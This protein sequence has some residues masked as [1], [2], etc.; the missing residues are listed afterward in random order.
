MSVAPLF[1]AW[2]RGR[3][4]LVAALVAIVL[5]R[6]GVIGDE[7]QAAL[8]AAVGQLTLYPGV[9]ATL[10]AGE[11]MIS[12]PTNIDV[13]ELGRVWVCDVENYR[14]HGRRD[15]RPEGD[16]ILILEDIDGDGVADGKKVFYQGRDVDAA[17]GIC[18]FDGHV[19]VTCAPNVILFR[20]EDGD[21]VPDSKTYLFSETGRPQDDHSTH[22]FVFGPDGRLYWNM[23][24]GGLYVHD[25]EGRQVFD[26]FGSPVFDRRVSRSFPEYQGQ[27]SPFLGGMVFRCALD[28]TDFEV[29]GHNFRNNYEVTVDSF[30]NPWQSDNDDDGNAGV[31]LNYIMEYGNY[32]YLDEMTA[33]SW[34]VPRIGEHPD[35]RRRHWHQNDPGVV[36][37][38]VQTGAGSPTG[39]TVYE[40][41]LLPGAFHNKVLH[42]DAGPG[43]LWAADAVSQESGVAGTMLN[44]V[45]NKT[46]RSFRPVDVAVAPDGSLFLSD[47]YDPVIGW[48]R[49]ADLNHGRIFRIAP[50][51]HPYR[52]RAHDFRSIDGAIEALKNP[53]YSVRAR[54]WRVLHARGAEAIAALETMAESANPVHRARAYWL[55][56]AWQ[57]R[58]PEFVRRAIQDSNPEIRLVGL[59]AAARFGYPLTPLLIDLT[60]DPSPVVRRECAVTLRRLPNGRVGS[61]WARLAGG[62]DG[63]DRWY[64]EALGIGAEGRWDE[65]LGALPPITRKAYRQPALRKLLWRSRA[66][67]TPFHL[68]EILRTTSLPEEEIAA[69]LRAFDFQPDTE[70]RTQ[71]LESLLRGQALAGRATFRD[72]IRYE[73]LLRIA[74]SSHLHKM[75]IQ[76]E[77]ISLIR[78][79]SDRTLK[80]ELIRRFE[81]R[82][83]RE[84]LTDVMG[85]E[86]EDTLRRQA[87]QALCDLGESE[88]LAAALRAP[89]PAADRMMEIISGARRPELVPALKRVIVNQGHSF[90]S[91][92]TA[93]R[94]LIE[95]GHGT[96]E[97]LALAREGGFPEDLEEVAGHS[98]SKTLHVVN[99]N[100]A[101]AFFPVPAMKGNE[102]LPG[103]TEL[104]VFAGDKTRG[105]EIF[106]EAS[107]AQC[108]RVG[109][110]GM[111]YGPDLS[112]I[113]S[114]L[115]KRGL[116]ESILDPDASISPSYQGI[117]V[118]LTSGDTLTGLLVSD[119]DSELVLNQPGSG[120]RVLAKGKISEVR[121]SQISAMP[122][123]LHQL[124]TVNELVDLVEFLANLTD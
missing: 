64:L 82:E 12:N 32:G 21:D 49:Q 44:L 16:Q 109:S 100:A 107:C 54:A 93:L 94:E 120:L 105:R 116:Y 9:G 111:A 91:R 92:S 37:N 72:R 69:L 86:A 66:T 30:G 85:S 31:R 77:A 45:E 65:C 84:F 89:G 24:N 117:E 78:E 10:F 7:G 60:G 52:P 62:F 14:S 13:D 124:M 41:T 101:A 43:V 122:S 73:A 53:S 2:V 115:S 48:N 36:P 26:Q 22:S 61:L 81:R 104:L 90:R 118:I 87:L 56:A 42:C 28:G 39:I 1:K 119:S 114:K 23:G 98:F 96:G 63:R 38:S 35:I 55:L 27:D 83:Q 46:N 103:M 5:S 108:H 110:L 112:R 79:I 19:I 20:D 123:G 57:P 68:A 18:V 76:A 99:R 113:G 6:F 33:E 11:P 95:G 29:L 67:V 71:Q 34:R 8:D 40:G 121:Y 80:I 3:V 51:D 47:W 74:R 70:L 59:R 25:Q 4:G 97:V 106:V 88:F 102:V 75:D 58:G 17:L 15:Q 50:V